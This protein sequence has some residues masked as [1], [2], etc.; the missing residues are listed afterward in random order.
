MTFPSDHSYPSELRT[1]QLLGYSF[2]DQGVTEDIAFEQGEDRAQPIYSF[3][4]QLV[5]VSTM[6]NQGQFDRFVEWYEDDLQAG[7]ARFDA[8]LTAQGGL[9]MA[10]WEAQFV[11]VW[12]AEASGRGHFEVTAELLLLDGPYATRTAPSLRATAP[13][14]LNTTVS[15]IVDGV[16]R[17][18]S[19]IGL[20]STG[21][22][23]LAGLR[24][25][26][27]IAL[28]TTGY[29]GE[30][31]DSL[32]TELGVGYSTEGDSAFVQETA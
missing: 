1:F 15:P 4:T 28:T 18:R 5:A 16:L 14:R 8:R 17:A 27:P 12:R 32:A 22:L 3:N 10:W 29:L 7:A 25:T 6:M 20:T 19:P 24:A 2:A 26:A 21:R 9:G 31:D 30:D 23:S 11:G 13:I